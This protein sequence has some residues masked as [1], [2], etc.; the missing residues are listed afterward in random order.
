MSPRRLSYWRYSFREGTMEYTTLP[1]GV[2]TYMSEHYDSQVESHL[3]FPSEHSISFFEDS[4]PSAIEAEMPHLYP[5][6]F[7]SPEKF[8]AYGQ[9]SKVSTYVARANGQATAI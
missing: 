2:A 6:L 8:R 9:L 3:A 1:I 4:L 5:N 7:S